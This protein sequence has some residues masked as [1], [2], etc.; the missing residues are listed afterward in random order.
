MY[1]FNGLVLVLYVIQ[2]LQVQQ[3][4]VQLHHLGLQHVQVD[5]KQL[6]VNVPHALLELQH[7]PL[8]QFQVLA[9]MDI[10]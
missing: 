1:L 10:S 5:I 8:V 3:V 4:L 2:Q 9:V 6:E 7:V